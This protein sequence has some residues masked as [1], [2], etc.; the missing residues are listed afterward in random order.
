MN[1]TI[2]QETR[3]DMG[4]RL[5]GGLMLVSWLAAGVPAA[6]AFGWPAESKRLSS[7]KDFIAE[8]QWM[9][10]IEVLQVLLTDTKEAGKDEAL[11]WL[12]HSQ[13]HAGDAGEALA[14]I[15]RLEREYPSSVWVKPAGALR[16]EIAVRLGRSDVLWMT[17]TP[18]PP[19]PPPTPRPPKTVTYAPKPAPPSARPPAP[20]SATPPPPPPPPP[21]APA[22]VTV[23][24][25]VASLSFWLPEGYEPDSDM[26]IQA[27]GHLMRTDPDK[28]IPVLKGI[29]FEVGNPGTA[30]RAVFVLAQSD[31]NDARDTVVQVAQSGP[32]PVRVAAVRELA[33]FG[34]TNV[35][36]IL[37][38]VYPTADVTVKHQVVKSLGERSDC[39]ALMKIA[40]SEMDR[41]LRTRT[42][43]TLG[44][45]G[46]NQELRLLYS[47]FGVEYKRPIIQ[48]LFNARAENELILLADRERDLR[49]RQELYDQLRL[50]GTPKAKEYLEK[51]SVKK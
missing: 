27:L 11:F 23:P 25:P 26:R 41:D 44:K 33:R 5:V 40:E 39:T 21:H 13:K 20:P 36:Q 22:M 45:A 24:P 43:L 15:R 9:R 30:S 17:A 8:E 50:L 2:W 10:A 46:G 7:A 34:G 3:D 42:I 51:V 48:G 37:L 31:R 47:K 4:K 14:T 29:A 32:V 49:I 38:S 28:A 16:L 35:S 12:A 19:P 1:R 6:A 18:P